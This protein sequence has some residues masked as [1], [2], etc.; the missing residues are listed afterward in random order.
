MQHTDSNLAHLGFARLDVR[1]EQYR[2]LNLFVLDEHAKDLRMF[3]VGRSDPHFL[4]KVELADDTDFSV[5]S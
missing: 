2:G 1:F 5:I 4:G 3:I